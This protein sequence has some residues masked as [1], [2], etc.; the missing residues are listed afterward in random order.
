MFSLETA[1]LVNGNVR[2]H[3]SK[4]HRI[5]Q[6]RAVPHAREKMV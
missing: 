6:L 2:L 4:M 5:C 1:L 3:E